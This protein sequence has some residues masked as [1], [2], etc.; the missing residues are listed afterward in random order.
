MKLQTSNEE[1]GKMRNLLQTRTF[2]YE[3][4]FEIKRNNLK[5]KADT[6]KDAFEKF[7]RNQLLWDSCAVGSKQ[8]VKIIKKIIEK[9]PRK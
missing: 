8:D 2:M 6:T 7:R 1:H 4:I 9:D 5:K 3:R